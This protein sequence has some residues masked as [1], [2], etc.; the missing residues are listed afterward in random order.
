M[1]N[2]LLTP[3]IIA[4]E[5]LRQL[6]NNC[7]MGRLVYRGY[8]DEFMTKSNGWRKGN[9]VTIKA[10]L[11]ARVK[12]GET[13][14]VVDYREEDITFTVDQ[15]KHIARKLTG[16]EMTLS[17]DAFSDRF[18]K[19]DIQALG[20]HIDHTLMGLYKYIPN[21]VGVPGVTPSQWLT[22]AEASAVMDDHSV[23]DN[24]RHCVLDP[25]A[26]IKLCDQLKGLLQP[27]T[28]G[29]AL[30][31]ASFGNLAGFD[32]YKSQN[33]NSHT[34]GTAAGLTTNLVD[35]AV[36]EGDTTI[37]IDQNGAWS[38]TLKQ[39]DIFTVASVNGVNVISGDSTGRLRQ[40]VVESDVPATGTEQ[41][42]SCTPGVAP[43][44]I[45]SKN[46]DETNLPYQ[47]VEDLPADNDA[48]NVAGSAS[49]NH[50]INMS[51]HKNCLGLV[52]VP[53]EPLQGLKSY[54]ETDPETNF[55]VTVTMGGDIINYVNYFR[56]DILYGV[57]ALNPFMGVRIAG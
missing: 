29:N 6:K 27:K 10:P 17:I 21:Q 50:K 51:F 35:G 26:Q 13:I 12:D 18:I 33:V 5:V 7:V 54:R 30:Q 22:I 40:F 36:S 34:C 31:K 52:M 14:D 47:T 56:A 4:K 38:N 2:T 19:P 23:P 37:T 42:I 1:A 48:I 55:T 46:A 3:S 32:M 57:K 39:G 9:S 45:Y 53:V 15:R 20:N 11:Q 49:L 24:D 25:W 44:N 28:V 41:A 8:E 16:T 43:W